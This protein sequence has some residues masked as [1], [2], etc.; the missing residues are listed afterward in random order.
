MKKILIVRLS[1]I[2]FIIA[3]CKQSTT[4]SKEEQ[5]GKPDSVIPVKEAAVATQEN[6]TPPLPALKD[7]GQ[8]YFIVSVLK[9]NQPYISYE[10]DFS[11]GVFDGDY[12][13]LQMPASKRILKISHLLILYFKGI[14]TGTFTVAP[15]GSEKGKP[16]LVFTPEKDGNYDIGVSAEE[17]QVTITKYSGNSVSGSIDAK[18]KDMDGN[19]IS[20]KATFINAKNNNLDQ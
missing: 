9:N 3:A 15:S 18:G 7:T 16:T 1:V 8:Q 5:K 20:I 11:I 4:S 2:F 10:G 19:T 17:G 13:I 12:F 14:A 6:E